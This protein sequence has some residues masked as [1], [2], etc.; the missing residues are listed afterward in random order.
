MSVNGITGASDLY[1]A[2]SA[3]STATTTKPAEETAKETKAEDVGVVYEKSEAAPASSGIYAKPDVVARLKA[4][5]ESRTAQLQ[6]LVEKLISQQ[7][8]TADKAGSIW[9]MLRTGQVEVDPET[10]AQAQKDIAEDGYWGVKQTSDRII[11]FAQALA[12]DDPEKLAKMKDAFLEGYKQAEKTWGGELP[13]IS[14][15]TYDAV[16]DK[17]D[18]LINGDVTE[19][20]A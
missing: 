16:L 3:Q 14:K 12:G 7:A 19:T 2:Y 11:E 5:A 6:S 13:E 8:G 18:K 1:S 9:D 20:Q 15:Q 4:D 17:F 10:R